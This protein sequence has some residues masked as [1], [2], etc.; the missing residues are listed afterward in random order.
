M[1][2]PVGKKSFPEAPGNGKRLSI[3]TK[4]KTI[5]Q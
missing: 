1:P 5:E 3:V 2:V 4:K